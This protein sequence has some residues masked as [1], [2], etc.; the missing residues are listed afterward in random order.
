MIEL[1]FEIDEDVI[2]EDLATVPADQLDE[3]ALVC[4]CFEFP[5]RFAVNGVELYEVPTVRPKPILRG[6]GWCTVPKSEDPRYAS[7]ALLGFAI[8]LC[9][10]AV[11]RNSAV[12]S[13]WVHMG[14]LSFKRIED[15]SVQVRSGILGREAVVGSD[16]LRVASLAFL[17]RVKS[18][19]LTRV[20]GIEK[21]KSWNK[22]FTILDQQ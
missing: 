17:R 4:T 13:S 12:D 19:F 16:E 7:V 22:W 21:H 15:G 8:E 2:K 14:A 1:D 18:F 5:M 11:P 10:I 9:G 20:P 6:E 3:A